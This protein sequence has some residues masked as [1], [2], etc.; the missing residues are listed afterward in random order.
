MRNK[1]ELILSAGMLGVALSGL[2]GAILFC[3]GTIL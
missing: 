2:A 3:I 1:F